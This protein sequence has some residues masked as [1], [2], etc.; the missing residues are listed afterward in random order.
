VILETDPG[1]ARF[2][3]EVGHFLE[4]DDGMALA[5]STSSGARN[6]VRLVRAS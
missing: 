1:R 3:E 6:R 2:L 4:S 5:D